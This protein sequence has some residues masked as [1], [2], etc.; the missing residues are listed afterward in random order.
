MASLKFRPF[1]AFFEE[2]AAPAEN[3]L[4]HTKFNV[5]ANDREVNELLLSVDEL[6][7]LAGCHID[8]RR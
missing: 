2:L 8:L 4:V 6:D 5:L 7:R 1:R 3:D